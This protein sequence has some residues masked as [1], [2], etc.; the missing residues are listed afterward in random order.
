MTSL[1]L[2]HE[3]GESSNTIEESWNARLGPLRVELIRTGYVWKGAVDWDYGFTFSLDSNRGRG[4]GIAL[5][6]G[7]GHH[8]PLIGGEVEEPTPRKGK[9]SS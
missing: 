2:H 7:T 4:F 8:W 6:G 9:G 5:T 1:R 3:R